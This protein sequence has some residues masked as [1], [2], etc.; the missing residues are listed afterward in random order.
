MAVPNIIDCTLLYCLQVSRERPFRPRAASKTHKSN[1][2]GNNFRP[3][4]DQD[5]TTQLQHEAHRA[6]RVCCS[7][8]LSS[9]AGG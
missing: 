4:V 9:G 7:A 6:R 3:S 1:D 8:H 2:M 5:Q